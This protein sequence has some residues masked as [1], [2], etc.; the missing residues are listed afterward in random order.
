MDKR[1]AKAT[2]HFFE[3]W[4]WVFDEGTEGGTSV[5]SA[6]TVTPFALGFL[7]PAPCELLPSLPSVL[8]Q[9]FCQ[10]SSP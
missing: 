5:W 8:C 7:F 4:G 1:V 2:L 10:K 6:V 3:R 9:S